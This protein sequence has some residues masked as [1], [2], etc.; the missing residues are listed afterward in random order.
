[1]SHTAEIRKDQ[2]TLF[3]FLIDQS[4]SMHEKWGSSNIRKEDKVAEEVNKVIYNLMSKSTNQSSGELFDR[5]DVACIGYGNNQRSAFEGMLSGREMVNAKELYELVPATETIP[6]YVNP[7]S[8]QGSTD[9]AGALGYVEKIIQDWISKENHMNSYP[10]TLIHITDAED[11]GGG[12]LSAVSSRIE[13]LSTN[14]GGT[15][16]W[17]IHIPTNNSTDTHILPKDDL[18]I[19]DPLAKKLFAIS[20]VLPVNKRFGEYSG[21]RAFGYNAQAKEFAAMLKIGTGQMT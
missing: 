19:T 11:T 6:V 1:M 18:N 21:L 17:T 15:L 12:D 7:D 14:D 13:A 8:S 2:R 4:G 5:F 3:V 10:P 20:S 9:I 16:I